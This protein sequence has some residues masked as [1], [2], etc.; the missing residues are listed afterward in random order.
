MTWKHIGKKYKF[1][2]DLTKT[3]DIYKD[4]IKLMSLKE[5]WWKTEYIEDLRWVIAQENLEM[6]WNRTAYLLKKKRKEK[7]IE[8]VSNLIATLNIYS[9]LPLNLKLKLFFISSVAKNKFWSTILEQ[10]LNS[11]SSPWAILQN[12]C[13]IKI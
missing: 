4:N 7:K 8:V 2:D 3:S 13:H 6:P 10:R 9:K 11:F 1:L 5:H 12:H